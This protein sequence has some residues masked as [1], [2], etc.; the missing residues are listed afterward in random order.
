MSQQKTT[1]TLFNDTVTAG[2]RSP[3]LPTAAYS[4]AE[5]YIRITGM[6]SGDE[7]DVRF[8]THPLVTDAAPRYITLQTE[9]LAQSSLGGSGGA[10]SATVTGVLGMLRLYIN[11]TTLSD[12]VDIK[13]QAKFS[14]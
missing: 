2:V 11:P 1:K 5:I 10:V 9:T 6:A 13:V 12:S 8:D 4:E 3:I 7:I 14:E